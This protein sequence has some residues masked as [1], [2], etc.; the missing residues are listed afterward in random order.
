[1]LTFYFIKNIAGSAL[2]F[3]ETVTALTAEACNG[4]KVTVTES[5]GKPS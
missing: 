5:V 2:R 4:S 1:V 3:A